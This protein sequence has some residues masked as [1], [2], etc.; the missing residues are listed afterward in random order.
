VNV[1]VLS[2]LAY[3]GDNVI[4]VFADAAEA[5]AEAQRLTVANTRDP[6]WAPAYGVDEVEFRQKTSGQ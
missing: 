3:G 6:R 1:Y 5:E 2:E 4:A